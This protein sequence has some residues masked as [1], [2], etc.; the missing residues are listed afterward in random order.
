MGNGWQGR[1]RGRF[2]VVTDE[3]TFSTHDE[4]EAVREARDTAAQL[5]CTVLILDTQDG[6][7]TNVYPDGAHEPSVT[8]RIR[9]RVQA[10][11]EAAEASNA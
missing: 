11:R 10:R 8:A 7:T 9:A 5:G 6:T 1:G 3:L 2:V 4:S